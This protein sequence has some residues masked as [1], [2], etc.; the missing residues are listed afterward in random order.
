MRQVF[1]AARTVAG[2]FTRRGGVFI[3]VHD[4]GGDFG[5]SGGDRAWLAGVAGIA[6]TAAQEW[7]LASVK[8]ID[9]AGGGRS[10][11]ALADAIVAELLEGGSDREVGLTA[12]GGRITLVTLPRGS[13]RD[14]SIAVSGEPPVVLA[15]GGGR[16]VTAACVIGLARRTRGRYILLGSTPLLEEP[17]GLEGQRDEASLTRALAETA[18]ASGD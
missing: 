18:R 16:G 7:P 14:P 11:A 12:A 8:A 1:R 6:K 2:A 4:S 3:T 9:L 5:R 10:A 13:D 17:P 15:A